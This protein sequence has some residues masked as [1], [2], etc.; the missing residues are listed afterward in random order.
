[1]GEG[2]RRQGQCAVEEGLLRARQGNEIGPGLGR[3]QSECVGS[4]TRLRA[5][6]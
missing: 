5:H 3:H 2:D 1:M 6:L 4:D